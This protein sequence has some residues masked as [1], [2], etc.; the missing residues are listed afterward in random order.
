MRRLN[1]TDWLALILVIVGALNWG[2]VG[3]FNFNLVD[4]IF[5]E[6]SAASRVVYALVGLSALYFAF[7]A[8]ALVKSTPRETMA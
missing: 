4:S 7:V 6:L 8:P 2:L 3:V 1:G 5:G